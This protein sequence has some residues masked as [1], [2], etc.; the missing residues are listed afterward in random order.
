MAFHSPTIIRSFAFLTLA[1]SL[2]CP[3][4]L[5]LTPVTRNYPVLPRDT[6]DTLSG[7]VKSARLSNPWAHRLE[8]NITKTSNTTLSPFA[9]FAIYN[10]LFGSKA[11][12]LL[13]SMG[14]PLQRPFRSFFFFFFLLQLIEAFSFLLTMRLDAWLL[15]LYFRNNS[16]FAY[17]RTLIR[18]T[19][20]N[21]RHLAS[22]IFV[23]F[24]FFLI[25]IAHS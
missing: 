24:C 14:Q 20:A 17:L 22:I 8:R 13:L 3:L 10:A 18:N 5:I 11:R 6:F 23:F 25:I 21:G 1:L 12:V 19:Q 2:P 9:P 15:F 16:R 7:F 4:L